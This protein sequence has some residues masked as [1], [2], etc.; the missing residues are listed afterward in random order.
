M[1]KYILTV[2]LCFVSFVAYSQSGTIK[3]FVYDKSNG[4]PILFANVLLENTTLGA[5][6]DD[7]GYFVVNKVKQGNYTLKV[8]CLGF[9]DTIFNVNVASSS[10]NLKIELKPMAQQLEAVEVHGNKEA[11]RIE[12]QVSVKKITASDIYKIPSIGGQADIAQYIQVLPGVV[13]SGDQG[14]QLYIRGGSAIQNKNVS[15]QTPQQPTNTMINN[16][17]PFLQ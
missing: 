17:G 5:S 9:K 15:V 12:S 1:K 10:I 7:N 4:E 16:T 3:G 13:S 11:A 6:T 14:G 2:V 8:Q